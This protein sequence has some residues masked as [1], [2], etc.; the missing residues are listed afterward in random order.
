[1]NLLTGE[2]QY[3]SELF[4]ENTQSAIDARLG[5]YTV[6]VRCKFYLVASGLLA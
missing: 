5:L 4:L 1:M 3:D 2:Q 6:L